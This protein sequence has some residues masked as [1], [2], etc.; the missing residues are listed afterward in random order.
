MPQTNPWEEDWSNPATQQAPQQGPQS[1][2]IGAAP[3]P[4]PPSPADIRNQATLPYDVRK[5]AADATAAELAAAAAQRQT[6]GGGITLTNDQRGA[7]LNQYRSL[8]NLARGVNELRSRYERDLRGLNPFEGRLGA[9]RPNDQVFNDTAGSLSAFVAAALGL[10]GQQ[11]NTPAEQQLFIGSILPNAADTDAQIVSKL[12]RLDDLLGRARNQGRQVLG[13]TPETDILANDR[14]IVGFERRIGEGQQRDDQAPATV[15]VGGQGGG[16]GTPPSGPTGGPDGGLQLGRAQPG[17]PGPNGGVTA[18]GGPNALMTIPGNETL[19][20]ELRQLVTAGAS[21]RQIIAHYRAR[22]ME[23]GYPPDPAQERVLEYAASGGTVQGWENFGQY[24]GPQQADPIR[25]AIGRAAD[26]N[27]GAGLIS[28]GNAVS[29]G[30]LRNVSDD[31]G[32]LLDAQRN[33]RPISTLV[34][35]IGGSAVAMSGV[36]RLGGALLNT[37]GRLAPLA[38]RVLTGGGGIGGDAL[39]GS[40]RGAVEADPG[41]RL[42]GALLGG[43]LGA[44]GNFL[45]SRLTSGAGAIATGVQ[46]DAVRYLTE[47]GIPLTLGQTLGNRGMFGRT[48]NRLESTPLI[49]DLLGA[50]RRDSIEGFNREAFNQALEP[51]GG[52]VQGTIGQEAIGLAQDQVGQAYDNALSGV[53][54]QADA[55]FVQEAGAALSQGRQ[56][57]LVGDRFGYAMD[58]R[59]GP[60]FDNNG[61]LDGASFQAGLRNVRSARPD[62]IRADPIV[63]QDAADA[64]SGVEDAL[65]NLAN[66]QAP[67]AVDQLNAA[68]RAYRS[69]GIIEDASL[70][71]MNGANGAGV[72]TPAQLGVAM[73]QNTRRFGGR[74]AAA[75]GDMPFNELQRFGQEVL[76]STVPDSGTAG[77]LGTLVLPTVLGGSAIGVEYF[78]DNPVA[79]GTLATLAALSTRRGGDIVQRA[80]V[81]R[82]NAVRAAGRAIQAQRRRGGMFGAALPSSYVPMLTADQ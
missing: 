70:N 19:G 6:A 2:V 23:A 36:N 30:A 74:G 15:P 69:L 54:L 29:A 66:R 35:D 55:P 51:I 48:L 71:A 28:A 57:P 33:E 42:Q 12:N 65:I 72:F 45:G 8:G 63:G 24:S 64:V 17:R 56:V 47:R 81:S 77:R 60:L 18:A 1:V 4:D 44:G 22:R 38:G 14:E 78:G 32:A 26:T 40:V 34:G 79:T 80:L 20:Q 5:A 37:G 21:R 16:S 59:L 61:G 7:L 53:Q 50:R 13:L 25:S 10:S 62:M 39:Y 43:T 3:R 9:L 52:Q 27:I 11:F 31:A 68:N 76:P 58:T 41:N 75:R 49:G 46:N 73:R 67:G 82:P